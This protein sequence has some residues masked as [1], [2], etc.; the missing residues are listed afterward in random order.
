MENLANFIF[1]L[2]VLILVSVVVTPFIGTPK[3]ILIDLMFMWSVYLH[4]LLNDNTCA[5]TVLEKTIRGTPDDESTFFGRLF[6][7][8]YEFGRDNKFS[9]GIIV[10]LMMIATYR[11]KE[12]I[13]QLIKGLQSYVRRP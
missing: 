8:A 5:L 7:K 13:A 1:G 6:G 2:H 4:W 12:E 10:F 3:W 9:W 11:S